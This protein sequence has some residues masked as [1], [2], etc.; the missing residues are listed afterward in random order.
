MILK[1]K[2]RQNIIKNIIETKKISTQDE[3]MKELSKKGIKINQPTISRDL[4]EMSVIKAAKGFG[5]FVYQMPAEVEVDLDEFRHKFLNLVL[6]IEHTDNLILIKTF[7]G[8][9][10]GLGKIIDNARLESI[11]GTV[12]GDDTILVVVD[13]EINVRKVL[14]IF[15]DV[16]KGLRKK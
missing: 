8:E 7:P 10:Q 15:E 11:L 9:A 3:L 2:A 1:K 6:G 5:R 16:K 13:K 12:A 4:R 14:K